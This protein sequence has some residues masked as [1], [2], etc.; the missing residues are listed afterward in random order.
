MRCAGL[1]VRL[2]LNG[3]CIYIDEGCAMLHTVFDTRFINT[4][5]PS[6]PLGI[7]VTI[8]R[9]NVIITF[10]IAIILHIIIAIGITSTNNGIIIIILASKS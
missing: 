3:L 6:I 7:K 4:L 8:T 5:T 10:I 2:W 1:A 9:L